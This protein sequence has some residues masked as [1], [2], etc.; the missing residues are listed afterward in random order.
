MPNMV[1]TKIPGMVIH[2][3]APEEGTPG[4]AEWNQKFYDSPCSEVPEDIPDDGCDQ[5]EGGEEWIQ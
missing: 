3:G 5:C 2:T 4:W 1:I